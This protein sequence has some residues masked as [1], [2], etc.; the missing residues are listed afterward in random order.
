MKQIIRL[1]IVAFLTIGIFSIQ[2]F[3]TDA[4]SI[5][6]LSKEQQK[7][8]NSIEDSLLKVESSATFNPNEVNYMEIGDLVNKVIEN[9]PAI[10]YY[11]SVTASSD[12]TINFT[13]TD[14]KQT[15]LDKKKK[16]DDEVERVLKTTIQKN[17][18]DLEKVKRIHDYLVLSVAYDM[19]TKNIPKDSFEVYG[20][21]I[22]KVAVCDGYTKSMQLLLNKVGVETIL[23][24][25]ASKGV[26]HSWN[27]VKIDDE[28]FH[29]DATWDDP[30]PN[31]PYVNYNY[32]LVT[33]EQLKKDHQWDE[34]AYPIVKNDN[35]SYFHVMEKMIEKD[36]SYYYVNSKDSLLYKM[37]KKSGKI[38]KVMNDKAPY[39]IISG[40]WI[41]Y[42][43][44]SNG[45]YLYKVKLDG[46]GKSQ[47]NSIHVEDLYMKDNVLHFKENKTN[48]NRTLLLK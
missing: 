22:N 5:G 23:V 8:Y 48:K 7:T 41:Y 43:N 47:I 10:F 26:N 39:F 42:S 24:S 20:A 32:F 30:V 18:T 4:S 9:N 11:A 1:I 35:Y 40:Q 21:L 25:G 12:G 45:G 34:K 15:I 46:N 17:M 6:E 13:Y 16:I 14:N 29:V 28:Y 27:I 31:K 44:Y 19:T 38:S 36:G 37:D 2:S 3:A 33:N